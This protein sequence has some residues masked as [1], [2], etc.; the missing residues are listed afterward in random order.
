VTELLE[1]ETLRERLQRGP[2]TR[3]AAVDIGRQIAGGLAAAHEKGIVHRDLKPANV[4]LLR[5]G[6]VKILDFGIATSQRASR[7]DATMTAEGGAGTPAPGV[8]VL[9]A[10][11]WPAGRRPLRHLRVRDRVPRDGRR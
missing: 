11:A 4:F 10:G 1:G 8:H 7:S 2:L 3:R 5:D 9:R 6:H